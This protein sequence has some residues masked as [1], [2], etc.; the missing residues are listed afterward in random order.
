[1]RAVEHEEYE[2]EAVHGLAHLG[3][4]L[5]GEADDEILAVSTR[6]G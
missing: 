3:G 2:E 1:L 4:D 6:L 5:V